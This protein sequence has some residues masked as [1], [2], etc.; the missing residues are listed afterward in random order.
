MA[1]STEK[2]VKYGI[3]GFIAIWI[4]RYLSGG[5]TGTTMSVLAVKGTDNTGWFTKW[6]GS[7]WSAW[8]QIKPVGIFKA[9]N[10]ESQTY[11][12]ANYTFGIGTDNALYVS[13]YDG[14]SWSA[15]KSGGGN[16]QYI[17]DTQLVSDGIRVFVKGNTGQ[18]WYN[19]YDGASF[20]GWK[21]AGS[22]I[23]IVG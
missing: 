1:I 17:I 10:L 7:A 18:A 5:T 3:F 8:A 19:T 4:I 22:T 16:S 6:T 12:G 13:K 15:W 2:L 21:T 20:K 9:S 11:N 23:G 14:T